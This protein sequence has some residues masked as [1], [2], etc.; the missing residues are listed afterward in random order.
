M[1]LDFTMKTRLSVFKIS[2]SKDRKIS[3]DIFL[4]GDSTPD[5]V[6]VRRLTLLHNVLRDETSTVVERRL[7][8]H[9][10][11]IMEYILH[12]WESWCIR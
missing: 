3:C 8:R 2:L 11:A 7:P 9:Q 10:D 1:K 5:P 4:P 6:V 12:L